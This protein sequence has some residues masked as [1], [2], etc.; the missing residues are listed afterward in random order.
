MEPTAFVAVR[1]RAIRI[2]DVSPIAPL[3]EVL[4]KP[5]GWDRQLRA[6]VQKAAGPK[7]TVPMEFWA[8]YRKEHPDDGIREGY[9]H[10]NVWHPVMDRDIAIGQWFAMNSVGVYVR[11]DWEC[12]KEQIM[13]KAWAFKEPPDHELSTT[14]AAPYPGDD[15]WMYVNALDIDTRNRANWPRMIE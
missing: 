9:A 15:H 3:F 8:A 14:A 5:S 1:I 6:S 13:D 2:G 12:S 11:P 4:E 10:T 7:Y